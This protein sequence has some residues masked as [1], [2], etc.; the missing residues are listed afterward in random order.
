MK[1]KLFIAASVLLVVSCSNDMD[2]TT[3]MNTDDQATVPVKVRV[4]DFSVTKEEMANGEGMT[5]TA[6]EPGGYS[7]LKAIDLAFYSGTT[8]V[9]RLSQNLSSPSSYTT[10]GEFSFD[11]PVGSYT[12]V[13]IGRDMYTGDVF[14]LTS[15]TAAAYT[16]E[17]P[18]ETF[19]H[20]QQVT[21]TESPLDLEVTLNRI[22]A[23]LT[24]K[25]TDSRPEGIASIRT[26]YA[27]GG[28][29]FNP[30]TGKA[31]SDTGFSQTNSPS[32]AVGSTITVSSCPF[33]A[34]AADVEEQINIT[35][36][37]L[38]A[39][40]EVLITK[41][42]EN[43]PFQRNCKTVLSGALFTVGTSAASFKVE[44]SW[45]TQKDVDF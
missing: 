28:K 27:K 19:C 11:L 23:M 45:G 6:T 15:P 13:A 33:L 3:A 34:T 16:S 10:F 20:V 30:T 1:K 39:D 29:A 9:V 44:T 2:F 42:I 32:T 8:E 14:T 36:E 25:S 41:T 24:I 18:R 21:V 31:T 22:T 4:N 5:R 12:M 38:N 43:V 7:S 26:T 35:I 37:V 40:N 17:R